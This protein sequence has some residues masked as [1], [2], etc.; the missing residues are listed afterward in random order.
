[1][2]ARE[3]I[4]QTARNTIKSNTTIVST[5]LNKVEKKVRQWRRGE[6]GSKKERKEE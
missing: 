6:S 5:F 4:L 3:E 1:M 2:E